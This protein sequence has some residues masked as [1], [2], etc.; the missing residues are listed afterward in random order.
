ME[1]GAGCR[2]LGLGVVVAP[3][4]ARVSM[5][6]HRVALSGRQCRE[7][8]VRVSTSILGPVMR[9]LPMAHAVD[10]RWCGTR[11]RVP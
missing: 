7:V 1:L 4:G 5:L 3:Y 6:G 2:P 11:V 10:A 8:C 9:V